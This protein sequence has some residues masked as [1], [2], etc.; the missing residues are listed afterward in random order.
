MSGSFE[1]NLV[2]N[3]QGSGTGGQ[4]FASE[5]SA[6]SWTTDY[7]IWAPDATGEFKWKGT[8][9]NSLAAYQ[10]GSGRESHSINGTPT[11]SNFGAVPSPLP[12]FTDIPRLARA[13][14]VSSVSP[15]RRFGVV[16][17][18]GFPYGF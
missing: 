10:T 9:Y 5:I 8:T 1:N 13:Y 11:F 4:L 6:N 14:Q 15:V 3:A 16:L 17:E 18:G 7:N 2:Y 12:A